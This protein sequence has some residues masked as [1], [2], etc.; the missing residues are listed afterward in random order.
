MSSIDEVGPY[1]GERPWRFAV[2]AGL[3]APETNEVC[4]ATLRQECWDGVWVPTH[5]GECVK[6]Q[7]GSA[8]FGPEAA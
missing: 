2:C 7:P 3:I 6:R 4:E 5:C 1:E 8:W